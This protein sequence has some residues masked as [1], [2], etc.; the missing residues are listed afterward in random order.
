MRWF[1]RTVDQPIDLS[2]TPIEELQDLETARVWGTTSSSRK[3]SFFE[4][5][6][7]KDSIL[8][9]HYGEFFATGK[10]GR[11]FENP[12]AGEWL[13]NNYDSRFIYTVTDYQPIS[14]SVESVNHLLGYESGNVPNGFIRVAENRIDSLLREY[15]SLD[16]A[17]QDVSE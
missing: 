15:S 16:E 7:T 13:W 8:F 17:I 1:N 5:M 11:S 2:G 12:K 14:I 9:Y 4:K 6:A 3:R 10:T